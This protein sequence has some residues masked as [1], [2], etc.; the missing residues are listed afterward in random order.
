MERFYHIYKGVVLQ[1]D[2]PEMMGRVKVWVPHINMTLYKAWNEDRDN[3]KILTE[4]GANLGGSLSPELLLRL[5][6]ALPW[7]LVKQ[8]IFGM[9][10]ATTYHADKNVAVISN[11]ED[12]SIQHE[13]IN[14][15]PTPPPAVSPFKALATA[16]KTT[17]V[18]PAPPN[19]AQTINNYSNPNTSS[20]ALDYVK[21]SV[22][23]P[24]TTQTQQVGAVPPPVTDNIASIV[25]TFNPNSRN[26]SNTHRRFNTSATIC[27]STGCTTGNA[28]AVGHFNSFTNTF[29]TPGTP[30]SATSISYSPPITYTPNTQTVTTTTP[31]VTASNSG[32]FTALTVTGNATT[33]PNNRATAADGSFIQVTFVPNSRN[34]RNTHRRFTTSASFIVYNQNTGDIT[35][36]NDRPTTV[37][38]SSVSNIEVVYDQENTPIDLNSVRL[39]QLAGLTGQYS[40]N[41]SVGI[42]VSPISPPS[43]ISVPAPNRGGGGSEL[44]ALNYSKLLPLSTLLNS[45][46][47]NANPTSQLNYNYK[48]P[49]ENGSDPQKTKGANMQ[50]A[51]KCGP[52]MISPSQ[53]NKAKGMISIPAVG[54][55][56]SV[57]FEDGDPQ[58]P[59]VDGV[60]YSQ[61][62]FAAIHDVSG[63]INA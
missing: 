1:N 39:G 52:P 46:V 63:P 40:N 35:V 38:L 37:N 61:E 55:H 15:L 16:M 18:A 17:G 59:I 23:A 36:N 6:N 58:Y 30:V 48:R 8:P 4:L 45:L 28:Q 21:N 41:A 19:A 60:F 34:V 47:G 25:I 12:N 22:A 3:D 9:G 54:A 27:D 53:N 13:V 56:V 14:K 2:D 7:G 11:D 42:P 62:S 49:P 5:K 24:T 20:T 10:T 29:T 43:S 33:Q 31:P 26:T 51:V 57:Y 32:A 50:T 44:F